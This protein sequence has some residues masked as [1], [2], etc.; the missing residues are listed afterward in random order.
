LRRLA[1]RKHRD[2]AGRLDGADATAFRPVEPG[3]GGA[4]CDDRDG[5]STHEAVPRPRSVA[6]AV[7]GTPRAL[8]GAGRDAPAAGV[9]PLAAVGGSGRTPRPA[10]PGHAIG[11]AG[12]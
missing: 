10:E 8:P 11:R 3:S 12:G 7:D 1:V 4:L 6:G 2:A 9:S 5:R